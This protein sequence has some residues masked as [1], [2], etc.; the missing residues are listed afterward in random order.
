M[1]KIGEYRFLEK[2]AFKLGCTDA[3][4]ILA[5]QVVV[6]NRVRL[7]CMVGCPTYGKNLKCPPYT[8]SIEEFRNILNEYSFAM[9]VKFKGPEMI[10]EGETKFWRDFDESSITWSEISHY[11]KDMLTILLELER[12]AFNKGYTF[13]TAF[14]AGRCKLCDECNIE[15]GC[16]NPIMAR[17]SAEAMGIN[18]LKTSENAGIT[19]RFNTEDNS[20]QT[21]PIAVLLID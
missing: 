2:E 7:K 20:G 8:P 12:T 18:V 10:K 21:T 15:E 9:V 3:S 11:Y 1:D 13:A 6:E 19:L 4:V 16:L 17:F 14:F 5:D